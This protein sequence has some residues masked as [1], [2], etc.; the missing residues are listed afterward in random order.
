MA[1]TTLSTDLQKR[2][3]TA[4][5]SKELAQELI[6]AIHLSLA[7]S[8]TLAPS[9][10]FWVI[11]NLIIATSVSQTVDFAS[12]AV[13]D[14]VLMIPAAAGSADQIGPIAVAGT[15]GQAAVVGNAYLVMRQ[16]TAP[17]S[18]TITW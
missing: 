15:L 7:D 11:A 9:Q 6:N 17:A 18:S 8:A 1:V 5:G 12:L 14:Q 4:V 16:F 10:T 13:G 2:L 3:I